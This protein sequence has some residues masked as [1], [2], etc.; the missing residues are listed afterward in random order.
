MLFRSTAAKINKSK[1]E[2][3][4]VP[5]AGHISTHLRCDF[6]PFSTDKRIRQAAALTLDREAFIKK[7]LKGQALMASDSI[8]DAFATKDTSVPQRKKDIAKAKA[9]MADAGSKGFNVDLSS[10]HRDDI[11][12]LA[13]FLKASMADIGINVTLVLA[14]SY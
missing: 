3:V 12:A 10:Y 5:S 4:K 1:A 13:P 8:M 9:L 14:D 11:D 6:G 7:V 2:L